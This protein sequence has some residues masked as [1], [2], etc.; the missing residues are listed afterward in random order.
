MELVVGKS[1]FA[2]GVSGSR[3][4]GRDLLQIGDC[5]VHIAG[6]AFDKSAVVESTRVS[7]SERQGLFEVRTGV[8]VSLPLD[9]DDG[10]VSVGIGVVRTKLG[11][12]CE[13]A[14]GGSILLCVQQ[15]DS[16][17]VPAHPLFV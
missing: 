3:K 17:V 12:A 16:V 8:V 2:M 13:S 14:G 7:R 5:H 6:V 4:A 1:Q 10:E 15:G 9:L 11:D